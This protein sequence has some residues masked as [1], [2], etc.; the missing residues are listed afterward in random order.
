MWL[1]P[2]PVH[3]KWSKCYWI[4]F[5]IS[6]HFCLTAPTQ[7]RAP[8]ERLWQLK[9]FFCRLKLICAKKK[10]EEEKGPLRAAGWG[11]QVWPIKISSFSLDSVEDPWLQTSLRW[12]E[13]PNIVTRWISVTFL[14]KMIQLLYI[15]WI[16]F[17]KVK[18]DERRIPNFQLASRYIKIKTFI[19][20]NPSAHIC[21]DICIN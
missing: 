13:S 20:Y 9:R 6:K 8:T 1:T 18:L 17:Q 5:A 11:K 15:R 16:E 10:K 12:Q 19:F 14:P 21:I 7:C 3:V 2:R 4:R